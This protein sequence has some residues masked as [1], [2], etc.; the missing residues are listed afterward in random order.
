M[1][2][3]HG[4]GF[5]EGAS[6][7][8]PPNYL[9][10]EDVVLVVPQ[11]RLDALGIFYNT[12]VVDDAKSSEEINFLNITGFLS[13]KSNEIPGNAAF[14]DVILALNWVQMYIQH[15]GG[16]ASCVTLFGQSSGGVMVSALAFSPAVPST[17]F[18]RIIVQSG[19]AMSSWAVPN[20][21]VKNARSIAAL[22]GLGNNLTLSEL[23]AGLLKLDARALL[24]ATSIHYVSNKYR[25]KIMN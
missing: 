14:S 3:I 1:I 15:F 9:M 8:Y 22:A 10:E 20:S 21:P 23:N 19:T 16:N 12:Y 4:G 25:K 17:L 7:W 11:Y 13:T 18:Q 6:Q 2:Y 5:Y 24:N